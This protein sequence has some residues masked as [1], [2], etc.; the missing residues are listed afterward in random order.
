[1]PIRRPIGGFPSFIF[2]FPFSNFHSLPAFLPPPPPP[3]LTPSRIP[4]RA[5]LLVPLILVSLSPCL[6][7]AQPWPDLT[8][9]QQQQAITQLKSFAQEA[10]D[11]L[12]VNL[13][14]FETKYF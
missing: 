1:M 6:F 4:L 3:P 10:R 5:F 13:S 2:H 12:G 11:S 9:A 7:A 8:D 14:A